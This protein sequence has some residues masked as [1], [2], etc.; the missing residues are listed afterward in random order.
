MLVSPDFLRVLW[1]DPAGIKLAVG[2]AIMMCVGMVWM[3]R[4]VRIHV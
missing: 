4:I 3:R 1:T 2:V